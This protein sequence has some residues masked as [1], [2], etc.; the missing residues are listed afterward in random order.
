M[1]GVVSSERH[2]SRRIGFTAH[3]TVPACSW[4]S[5]QHIGGVKWA[6]STGRSDGRW[7][8]ESKKYQS[9]SPVGGQ[10]FDS[11]KR[12]FRTR[13]FW[14]VLTSS[15]LRVSP[16]GCLTGAGLIGVLNPQSHFSSFDKKRKL[17]YKGL[18]ASRRSSRSIAPIEIDLGAKL[19]N[20]SRAACCDIH[21]PKLYGRN[22]F[23]LGFKKNP[24]KNG[25]YS[26]FL[27][28]RPE[29]VKMIPKF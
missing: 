10:Q 2:I 4:N 28:L 25:L 3:L 18:H 13:S 11:Q 26:P 24:S 6:A 23:F 29:R 20:S 16:F 21:N 14:S 1:L 27:Q 15:I 8:I 22:F 17:P 12:E 19:R 5:A 9:W 7:T